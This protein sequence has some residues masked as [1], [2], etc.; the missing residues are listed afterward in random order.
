MRV[1]FLP[2]ARADLLEIGDY[3]AEDSPARAR[4]FVESLKERCLALAEFPQMGNQRQE[5][6]EGVRSLTLG[7]YVIYYRVEASVEIIRILHSARDIHSAGDIL[8]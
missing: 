6:K 3:I 7:R 8:P 2:R 5:L 4:A 1:T